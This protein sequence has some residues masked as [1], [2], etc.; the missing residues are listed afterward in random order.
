MS[1]SQKVKME[2]ESV[3]PA[4]R[5]CQIAE[6]AGCF[7]LCGKWNGRKDGRNAV[8][9]IQT[10]NPAV[11]RIC[12]TLLRKVG[13]II[14]DVLVRGVKNPVYLLKIS[15]DE[16]GTAADTLKLSIGRDTVSDLLI[17]KECCKRA[18]I[19]GAFI[20]AGSMNDPA[21]SYH[22][23]IV[24]DTKEKAEQ[25]RDVINSFG[26]NSKIVG[27]KKSFVVY[28]K[29]GDEIVTMLNIM[30]A[31]EAL[32]SMENTRIIK[33][34]RNT[35]N[36]RVNCETA[37]I[38]KT[39][40]AAVKQ[41][42]DIELIRD[43]RGLQILSDSLREMAEVRLKYPEATLSELGKYLSPPVGKSGVNHRLRKLSE[44]ADD[45]RRSGYDNEDS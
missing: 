30:E 26:M 42:N 45:I 10:E 5:H 38:A 12:F 37:N 17:E 31:P 21:R 13:R 27:R 9:F 34:M 18:L 7:A 19:R 11:A 28:L 2:I 4:S 32:M 15:G 20:A 24:C 14:V 35:V 16:A 39:V 22:M 40:S 29:E 23:E 36:R 41:V 33:E 3:I 43:T 44:I 6:L 1:F 8:L 25:I